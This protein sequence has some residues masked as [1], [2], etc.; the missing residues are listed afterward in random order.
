MKNEEEI[1]IYFLLFFAKRPL[2]IEERQKEVNGK[3][4]GVEEDCEG[5]G[6]EFGRDW[7]NTVNAPN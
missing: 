1:V 5:E 4:E 2:K 7:I 3:E 6:R